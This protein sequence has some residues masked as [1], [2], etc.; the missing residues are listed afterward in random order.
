MGA[1]GRVGAGFAAGPELSLLDGR[2]GIAPPD[3]A[4][5][6]ARPQSLMGVAAS[7]RTE[8]RVVYDVDGERLVLLATELFRTVAGDLGATVGA[9]VASGPLPAGQ[10]LVPIPVPGDAVA[11][12]YQPLD[13]TRQAV[14]IADAFVRAGDASIV[15]VQLFV[16]PNA[17]D[18]PDGLAGLA[19]RILSTVTPG[20]RKPGAAAGTRTL[21]GLDGRPVLALDAPA[22]WVAYQEFGLSFAVLRLRRLTPLD[23]P[24]VAGSVY[25]GSAPSLVHTAFPQDA[26]TRTGGRLLGLPTDWIHVFPKDDGAPPR[27]LREALVE[28]GGGQFVHAMAETG[29]VAYEQEIDAL[30]GSVRR[31]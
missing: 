7:A 19:A 9:M 30:L 23:G 21:A 2:L 24:Y 20:G 15:R 29:D 26:V 13:T 31:C 4:R 8:T 3:G 16:S 11:Y 1:L 12:G 5:V 27:H 17:A 18:D 14:P 22:G 25:R 28:D 6:E 10:R